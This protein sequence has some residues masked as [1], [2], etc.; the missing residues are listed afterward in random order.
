MKSPSFINVILM[1]LFV[2]S[3]SCICARGQEIS[4]SIPLGDNIQTTN[5]DIVGM[6]QNNLLIYK[7]SFNDHNMA[8]YDD[9]MHIIDQVPLKFLP[10]EVNQEDFITFPN[11]VLMV[12][13]YTFKRDIYCDAVMLGKD[14]QPLSKPVNL[15]KTI[16]P[17]EVLGDKAYGVIYSPDRDKIM[18]F[19]ILAKEG[20]L[21]Y[22][23]RTS[24][25]DNDMSILYR[26]MV[27]LPYTVS[28]GRP[29]QFQLGNNGNVYFLMGNKTNP[30]DAYYQ[31]LSIYCKPAMQDTLLTDSLP[32]GGNLYRTTPIL[33]TDAFHREIW[34]SSF[35]FNNKTRDVDR[36]VI[37]NYR[38]GDLELLNKRTILLTDSIKKSIENKSEGVRETFDDYH[39]NHLI[40]DR[41][42]NVLLV[43]EEKYTDANGFVH[44]NSLILFSID[45]SGQLTNI[46]KI[47]KDQGN[48]L[49]ADFASYLM[50]NTGLAL[51]FLMNKSH[52]V[53][54]FLNNYRYLL[55]DYRYSADQ[56]LELMPTMRGLANKYVW[57]PRYGKQVG[58]NEAVIPCTLG[59]SLF[60][61][62]IT[63]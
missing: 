48:D 22:K 63:Y 45:S 25:Y 35:A 14:A 30:S 56:K 53:F 12:Y 18:I 27:E 51:H 46:Q 50:V 8:L 39:L 32:S 49:S 41:D 29:F 42:K 19:E 38:E 43:G 23:I 13:Q 28:N 60:F 34:V 58:R 55:T 57:A 47:K 15:D 11:K 17:E 61:A 2:S 3:A 7:S 54:R 4:Y 24:L 20:Q 1:V 37:L 5:F 40:I 44:Y 62:K 33:K 16:H 9:S 36:L 31:S 6:C 21:K 52:K 10:K 26:G 59:S